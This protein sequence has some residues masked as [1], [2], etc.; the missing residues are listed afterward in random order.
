MDFM[1]ERERWQLYTIETWT[2]N[3]PAFS[4]GLA[5]RIAT[6]ESGMETVEIPRQALGTPIL[7]PGVS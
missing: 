4:R 5:A 3:V 6:S 7:Y 1:Q 2:D